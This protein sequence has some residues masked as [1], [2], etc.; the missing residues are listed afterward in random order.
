M[1]LGHVQPRGHQRPP[2]AAGAGREAGGIAVH[3]RLVEVGLDRDHGE[4][5]GAGRPGGIEQVPAPREVEGDGE[6]AV[7]G[8]GGHQ[9]ARLALPPLP[10]DRDREV[11]LEGLGG[12]EH[13][14]GLAVGLTVQAGHRPQ[15]GAALPGQGAL[16]V[17]LVLGERG[18]LEAGAEARP[19]GRVAQGDG[20]APRQAFE[21]GGF[22][23]HAD[24]GV[25][26]GR[27]AI[28]DGHGFRPG[29]GGQQRRAGQAGKE[30]TG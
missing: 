8:G 2:A 29:T 9:Q 16:Q 17:Q 24:A 5:R 1:G 3:R 14:V 30:Q 23:T 10:V 12:A 13:G 6:V 27:G 20:Q 15:L 22:G 7:A 25:H 21:A 11:H 26:P 28:G 18:G 19:E 4:H